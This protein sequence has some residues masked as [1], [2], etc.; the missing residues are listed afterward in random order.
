MT[1]IPVIQL[2]LSFVFERIECFD[3]VPKTY[4]VYNR[5]KNVANV[6]GIYKAYDIIYAC[7]LNS[8]GTAGWF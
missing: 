6:A 1:V 3:V 2:L 8:I 4:P 7:S 5:I